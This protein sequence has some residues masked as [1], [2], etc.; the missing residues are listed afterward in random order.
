MKKPWSPRAAT[1]PKSLLETL[2]P[3]LPALLWFS[4]AALVLALFQDPLRE[5]L[6]RTTKLKVAGVEVEAIERKLDQS[7][8]RLQ[9]LPETGSRLRLSKDDP[10]RT[11]L[12]RRWDQMH[13]A[14]RKLRVLLLHDKLRVARSLREPFA[15]LGF[16]VDLGICGSEGASLLQ[17][18]QYDVVVSDIKWQECPPSTPEFA[19]GVSFLAHAYKSGFAQP[20]VFY[21]ENLHKERGTP[22]YAAGITNNWYEMLHFILDVVA[23][24][25]KGPAL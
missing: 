13:M 24:Q 6:H 3:A 7:T 8:A 20:T 21:I 11:A 14:E 18:H 19:D 10:L 9:K 15:D 23:R 4:L 2:A 5:L 17:R 1:M 12:I 16:T 22:A 25:E